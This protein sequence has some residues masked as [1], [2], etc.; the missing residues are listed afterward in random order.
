MKI[1]FSP[2]GNSDPW[3]NDRDGAMLHIVRHY[4]LDKVVLYFTRTIWEGNENRKGHKIYEWEKIIQTVSP[5][6]E[7][8]IIIENVD[9]AQDYDVF[10]EKFHKYLKIIEDSYEDCEII[11]NVTSGTPQME[12]TLCLEYIVYPENKKCVQVSTPTKDS[13]AGIEYS[14]PKDKVEEFEIV[15]EVEKK[16]EKRC[17]EINILSFREAMIRSQILGLIDNYDYEGALNLVSNQKSF[18]NGKFLRKKLLSLTKQIKTHEVFPEIN[19]KYRDDALKKSLFHYLLLNMRYNR[20][21]VAETL[22]RVKSIA[23][24]ILKTYIEIHWPTLIIE[25][26]GKPYLNDEDNLSFV[27]KYNL[28]LEKRKQNFDVSRILGLPAFIDI[29]TILEPNSQLLKEVNAVNDINGLRNSIAHNL[30]T[31]NLDKNKNYKKIMLSV[32][33]IKNMLHISFPEIEEEDYNYFEEKNKEFKE[34][35]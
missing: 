20:L 10:K 7:V 32:E 31:L 28:L 2:I 30:D 27:Y 14:N 23:E 16:S 26:D 4:N 15:N 9:N 25:K 3:R 29:L 11:L 35:L 24:F 18:R 21:D 33:A 19:E 8:E 5:N 22:I 17:K 6:T 34:L 12:S 1:L 13:N